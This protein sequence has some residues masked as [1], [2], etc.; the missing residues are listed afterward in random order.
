MDA[1]EGGNTVWQ[2]CGVLVRW[3]KNESGLSHDCP[4]LIIK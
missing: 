1:Q 3:Q 2:G 4:D